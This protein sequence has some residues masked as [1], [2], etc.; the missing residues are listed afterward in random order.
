L[1]QRS[2]PLTPSRS[3]I[4]ISS[5]CPPDNDGCATSSWA[6]GGGANP[7]AGRASRQHAG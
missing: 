7:R 3:S 6:V 5:E 4:E 2:S 1:S